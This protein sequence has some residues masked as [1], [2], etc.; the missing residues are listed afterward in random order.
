[1][2]KEMKI[3]ANLRQDARQSLVSISKK[4]DIPVST[5]YE[6]IKQQESL[7]IKKYTSLLDFPSLGF[8]IRAK[9][10]V[11]GDVKDY[12]MEHENV[13]SVFQLNDGFDFAADC[14]FKHMSEFKSFIEGLDGVKKEV[15]FVT[16]ELKREEFL[17]LDYLKNLEGEK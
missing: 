16:D 14:I 11:K 4:T 2:C 7:T 6:K 5:V 9:I 1:M 8:N 12:L 17:S 10:L 3:L 13:N 15:F